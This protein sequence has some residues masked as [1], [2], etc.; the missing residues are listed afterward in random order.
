MNF[1]LKTS[2][3]IDALS[4]RL[5]DLLIWLVLAAAAVSAINATMRKLFD[6]SSNAFLE[7]Q[8]YLF[9]ALFLLGAGY[10]LLRQGHVKID[11]IL[12]RFSKRTQI[13]VECFGIVFFLLPFVYA[14][15]TEI[16]PILSNAFVTKEMSES[17]GGLM[18]WPVYAL[19][20]LGFGLLGL[21]GL[22]ELIKRVGFL[23]G[24]CPDP[25]Q[26]VRAKSAEEELAEEIR[27]HQVAPEVV[28]EVDGAIG[29]AGGKAGEEARK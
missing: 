12:G 16:W 26:A 14:V 21:Q 8:W 7:V 2:R 10:T 20:P 29:M 23:K 18:R 19:V 9:A 3:R 15:I 22:S 5:G 13:L 4:E 17:P 27:K 24:L 28:Q 25:T 1:L 6:I 11:V